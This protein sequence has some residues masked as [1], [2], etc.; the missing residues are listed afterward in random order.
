MDINSWACNA[1][2]DE[3]EFE[4]L[5]NQ[6]KPFIAS[7]ASK[8][9][10]R[11][12][13]QHDDEMS[14][15]MIAFS[16][17]VRRYRPESGKFLPFAAN[18]IRS[19][20]IDQIRETSR[21]PQTCPLDT[22]N[23]N[24]NA[25]SPSGA[26]TPLCLVQQPDSL[27]DDPLKLEIVCL[28]TAL[29]RYHI[30]FSDVVDCSPRSEKTKQAAKLVAAQFRDDPTLLYTLRKTGQLPMIELEKRSGVSRKTISRHRNYIVC[31]AEI[32]SGEYECLSEYVYRKG[33]PS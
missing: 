15:A 11:H 2:G 26:A 17:A 29:S 32:L 19:R 27:Y 10:G 5:I 24:D 23:T 7:C 25:C 18:V 6:Y 9:T 13:D 28:T 20:L 4:R 22:R 8:T 30:R 3:R 16:E 33:D 14:V 31:L 21:E 12:I 1:A